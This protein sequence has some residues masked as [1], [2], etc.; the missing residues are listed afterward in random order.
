[1]PDIESGPNL[2]KILFYLVFLS[3]I[4]LI[5]FY[6]PRRILSQMKHVFD[7]YPPSDYPR[8]YP[9][10]IEYY[11]K[12]RRHYRV[13]NSL[14]LLV[15][16]LILAGLAAYPASVKW[17]DRS[18]FYSYSS[19]AFLYFFLQ[20]IPTLFL[21][22]SSL[23]CFKLMRYANSSRK[24]ELKPR[25]LFDFVSPGVLGM[26]VA[27][28]LA[29]WIFI[30]YVRT[31]EFDWFGGFGNIL[32]ATVMNAFFALAVFWQ[33]Y[34]KKRDPHQAGE[35]RKRQISILIHICVFVSIAATVFVAISVTLS[36]LDLR[37]FQPVAQSMYFQIIAAICLQAYRMD[38]ITNFE[39]YKE[40][41]L[42][43]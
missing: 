30:I 27:I 14:I 19:I 4:L 7:N 17:G 35:D 10:P 11:G 18:D 6:F 15:G 9:K 43:A 39:V 40:D 5:S 26:A 12:R 33:I 1:M 34:G 24:A 36:A 37:N 42:V 22:I 2:V 20:F 32:G 13:M 21:D 25:R 41:P 28:Y 38:S 31:F 23:K 16:L 8:L 3:Q 29:F